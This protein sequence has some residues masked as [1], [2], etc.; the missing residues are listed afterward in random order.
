VLKEKAMKKKSL[1]CAAMIF[2][3]ILSTRLSFGSTLHEYLQIKN[4]PEDQ[5]IV[6]AYIAGVGSGIFWTSAYASKVHLAN[7]ICPPDNLVMKNTD[8]LRI[9]NDEINRGHYK[10]D[11]SIQYILLAGILHTYP[12]KK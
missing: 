2:V 12:C 11:D 1:V 5:Q 10:N 7:L 6:Q 3:G 9:L 4:K 8:Y